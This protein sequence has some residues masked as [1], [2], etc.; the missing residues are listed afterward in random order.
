MWPGWLLQVRNT[1]EKY[2]NIEGPLHP[3]GQVTPLSSRPED[4]NSQDHRPSSGTQKPAPSVSDSA[5]MGAQVPRA[6]RGVEA[7]PCGLQSGGE[8]SAWDEVQQPQEQVGQRWSLPGPSRPF[9]AWWHAGSKQRA[10]PSL[11]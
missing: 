7:K 2:R 4:T 10:W 6:F 3:S 9:L 11:F 1:E 5:R 8:P